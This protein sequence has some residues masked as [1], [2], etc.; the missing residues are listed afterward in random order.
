MHESPSVPR[1]VVT[2]DCVVFTLDAEAPSVLL[3]R[4]GG[5]P[6]LGDWALPGGFL[7]ANETPEQAA[8]RE[9]AEET[10]LSIERLDQFHTFGAPDRDPRGRT[11]SVAHLALAASPPPVVRGGSDAREARWFLLDS[12]PTLAF[13]HAAIV[14]L[15]AFHLRRMVRYEASVFHLLPG[16][17]TL[18]Q[19]QRACEALLKSVFDKRNFRKKVMR[20]G[21]LLELGR[22][23]L[24]GSHRPARLY[25]FDFEAYDRQAADRPPLE[26]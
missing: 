15:A 24:S 21:L 26:F 1:I 11:L 2:V 6:F 5:P 9:L 23:R 14:A 8:R 4:R 17:F 7:E 12:L 18:T 20:T 25:R 19:L 13:D 10:G 22:Q 16:E 3:I